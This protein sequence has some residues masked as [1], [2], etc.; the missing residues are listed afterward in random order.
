MKPEIYAAKQAIVLIPIAM[1]RMIRSSVVI[2]A[3]MTQDRGISF[4]YI[5]SVIGITIGIII[6]EVRSYCILLESFQGDDLQSLLVSGRND[7]RAAHAFLNGILPCLCA[8][9]PPV[10]GGQSGETMLRH[11]C[12]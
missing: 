8:D 7:H 9:T 3:N 2:P 10:A 4:E 11:G 12:D 5:V 6:I 1:M